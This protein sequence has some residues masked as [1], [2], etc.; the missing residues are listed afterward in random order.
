MNE[1]VV[2][3]GIVTAEKIRFVLY[4]AFLVSGTNR[5]INGP[6]DAMPHEDG[7]L[8]DQ[9]GEHLLVA[10]GTSLTPED[11]ESEH[12]TIVNVIV[13]KDFH[14]ERHEKQ[15]FHGGLKLL[16]HND[17]ITAVNLVHIE[18]YLM[19]VISSEMN[20]RSNLSLMK[21]QAVIARSWTLAQI[22]AKSMLPLAGQPAAATEDDEQINL[23]SSLQHLRFDVC[24]DDHCQRYHGF[25]KI[26]TESVMHA[27]EQTRG[28]VLIHGGTICD[29]RYSRC[30]GGITEDFPNV[31][32]DREVPYLSSV[33]D[34]KYEPDNYEID[35]T[36]G[37]ENARAWLTTSPAAYCN[38]NEKSVLSQVLLHY[39]L[40]KQD[41]YRW[42]VVYDAG[43]LTK[44][45]NEK[46]KIDI[47]RLRSLEPVERGRSGRIIRLR[48]NGTERSI[49]IGK[50][51]EI[52]RALSKTHLY[53]AA[54]VADHQYADDGTLSRVTLRGGGWGHGVGLCQIG[55]AVMSERG[56]Q[57]DEILLHYYNGARIKKIY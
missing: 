42:K 10:D 46:L 9:G 12:F 18:E 8:L 6:F 34:Y 7:I 23:Y 30:C 26:F 20:A 4:G 28:L 38:T 33:I 25:T 1:P 17:H 54:F 35:F 44:L 53:S 32:E 37:E 36:N 31:W 41:Y 50:E 15:N 14:W 57:F 55:A 19:S 39:D 27:V 2:S 52:R 5:V 11:V 3:V 47:G 49:T 48:I 43:D 21:A 51:L 13:G 56:Y 22:E 40:E 29:A 45:I 16:A 24:A